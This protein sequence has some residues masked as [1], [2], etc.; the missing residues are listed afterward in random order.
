MELDTGAEVSVIPEA[1]Y[2]LLFPDKQLM[3]SGVVLK[4]YTGESI[5]VARFVCNTK[6]NLLT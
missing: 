4:T 5:T 2:L 6:H 1:T 3:K